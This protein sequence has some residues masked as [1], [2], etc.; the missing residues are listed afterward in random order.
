MKQGDEY[1]KGKGCI[2]ISIDLGK[3]SG[4]FIKSKLESPQDLEYEKHFIHFVF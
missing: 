2:R 4:D 1:Y 3:I